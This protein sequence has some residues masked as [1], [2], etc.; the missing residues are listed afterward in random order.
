MRPQDSTLYHVNGGVK[1][2][3]MATNSNIRLK[4]WLQFLTAIA[5]IILL[6]TAASLLRLRVDLTEDRRFTLSGATRHVLDHLKNDIYIQVYLDGEIP[7]P[8]KRLKRSVGEMLDE[9][10]IVSGRKIDYEFINPSGDK[11]VKRREELYQN[12][13]KKGLNPVDLHAG[14][15]EGGKSE[16]IIFPGMI[17]NYNG[18]EVPVNFLNNSTSSYEQNILRSIEGL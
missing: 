15:A 4:S 9:F 6:V 17:I 14:D 13:A 16:K 18:I 10:K 3:Q 11:D 5:G 8:L 12:L 1:I 2:S 7:I